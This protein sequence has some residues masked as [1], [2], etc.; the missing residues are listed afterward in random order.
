MTVL[1]VVG[2]MNLVWMGILSAVIF[3][4]KT[5]PQG[6]VIGKLTGIA[7]ITLGVALSVGVV[8][9]GETFVAYHLEERNV[10]PLSGL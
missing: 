10:L 8:P 5:V 2:S 9:F 4:E 6:V 7:L 3:V 1:F